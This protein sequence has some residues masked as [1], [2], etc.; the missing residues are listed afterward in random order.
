[1]QEKTDI[2]LK[3]LYTNSSIKLKSFFDQRIEVT[4]TESAEGFSPID[5]ISLELYLKS[6]IIISYTVIE[7]IYI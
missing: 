1:M 5:F 2:F 3:C 7:F 6:F 4:I